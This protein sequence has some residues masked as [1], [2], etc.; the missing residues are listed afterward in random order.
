V[1]ALIVGIDTVTQANRQFIALLA[2]RYRLP[3]SYGSR[4][5]VEAG[6]LMTYGVSYPDLY[7]RE[8]IY[9]EIGGLGT[10]HVSFEMAKARTAVAARGQGIGLGDSEIVS[11]AG[12]PS[13][14]CRCR[15]RQI[16]RS[17]C[18]CSPCWTALLLLSRS[19]GCLGECLDFFQGEA[20]VFVGVH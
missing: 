18:H 11:P 20:A 17:G 10:A 7:R 3:A 9:V 13:C 8:A 14:R 4:E 12:P 2:A 5:F 16:R 6:G 15:R 19:P 1:D